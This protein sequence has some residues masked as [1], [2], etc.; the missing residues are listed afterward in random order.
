V[1]GKTK[2]NVYVLLEE[3]SAQHEEIDYW[4][5]VAK[6][7]KERYGDLEFHCDSA[8]PE[9]VQRFQRERF[10]AGNA[11]KAVMSGI[12]EVA[13]RFKTD[14][15]FILQD[16]VDLFKQEIF[17]YA[18][19]ASTGEPIKKWDDVLDSLRYAIYTE[20]TKQSFGAAARLY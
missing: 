7:V 14:K 15:L 16:K 20:E 12:E 9:H 2:D 11:N 4:V 6:G 19:N 17:Q 13:K 3:H 5:D 10:R 1:L 18:W 8:R